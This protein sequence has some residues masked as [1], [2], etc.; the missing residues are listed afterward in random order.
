MEHDLLIFGWI[1]S[2]CAAVC[3]ILAIYVIVKDN[4]VRISTL[5]LAL[6]AG[7]ILLFAIADL[8]IK[9]SFSVS[10]KH[11]TA[12]LSEAID[13]LSDT[14]CQIQSNDVANHLEVIDAEIQLIKT[15]IS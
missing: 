11:A 10:N 1:P 15:R 12:K 14:I 3:F 9:L 4:N 7:N 5:A 6:F 13:K 2:V 8:L